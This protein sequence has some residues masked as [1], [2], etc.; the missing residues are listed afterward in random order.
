MAKK[1]P[2]KKDLFSVREIDQGTGELVSRLLETGFKP[3]VVVGST[4]GGSIL[5][6]IIAHKTGCGFLGFPFSSDELE[7]AYSSGRKLSGRWGVLLVDDVNLGGNV[8]CFIRIMK[9]LDASVDEDLVLEAFL[10][11]L[12]DYV[13]EAF[14]R[15]PDD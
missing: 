5:G 9:E 14:A 3:A 4:R 6:R 1:L 15:E 12:I 7:E 10:H 11:S 13:A 8:A 2:G